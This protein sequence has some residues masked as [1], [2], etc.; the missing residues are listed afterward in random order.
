MGI[1]ANIIDE[2]KDQIILQKL[3]SCVPQV[4]DEIRCGGLENT[5][6][7]RVH[8]VVWAYDEPIERVNIGVL[9]NE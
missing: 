6:F 7:Y 4:G 3:I 9:L 1:Q 2:I 5:K 8:R